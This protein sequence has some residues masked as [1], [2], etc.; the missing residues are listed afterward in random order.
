MKKTLLAIALLAGFAGTAN[1]SEL[2]YSF[3]EA[4]YVDIG[5]F[6]SGGDSFDGFGLRG[7]VEFG[8]NFY[9]LASYN[10]TSASPFGV[11]IDIDTYDVGLGFHH[12]INDKADFFADASYSHINLDSFGGGAND[13]GYTVN[14][15]F[16]GNFNDHF[17]GSIAANHRDLGDFGSDSSLALGAHIKF[18]ETWGITANTE[19]GGDDTRYSVGVR[20]SF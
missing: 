10:S 17:E 8:D 19:F 4:D 5:D 6:G 18:N 16:R 2:S 12:S 14:V 20:A 9:G 11:N 1:A 3:V 7:S 13:N 15:G